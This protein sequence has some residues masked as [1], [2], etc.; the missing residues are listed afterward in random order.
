MNHRQAETSKEI[1]L[2]IKDVIIPAATSCGFLLG[3]F[4]DARKYAK[5][6]GRKAKDKIKD[7]VNKW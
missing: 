7:F 4:P 6:K 1:R 3:L 5:E 2:W